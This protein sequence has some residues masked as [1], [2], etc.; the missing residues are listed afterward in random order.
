[1]KPSFHTYLTLYVALSKLATCNPF[2]SSG[3][4]TPEI[5]VFPY[6][7]T[8]KH[9][10]EHRLRDDELYKYPNITLD[11]GI[12]LPTYDDEEAGYVLYSNVRYGQ[13]PTGD[14]RWALPVG[15]EKVESD[16]PVFDGLEGNSCYQ[17]APQ[18]AIDA[19]KT[20]DPSY[21][22]TEVFGTETDGEDCLFLDV[23][24]PLEV[25]ENEQYPVVV[26][27][28]CGAFAYGK[29]DMPVYS[30]A[31]LYRRANGD[32]FIY[33]AFNYRVRSPPTLEAMIFTD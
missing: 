21:N 25:V 30:P 19:H 7:P 11:H 3:Y 13:N 4:P 22:W 16:L 17:A 28:Y 14:L 6:P 27:F 23:A 9:R 33:V 32:K 5:P 20:H 18:W 29:K 24:T 15:P 8:P 26:W 12:H 2:P 31:G 1:M 10:H